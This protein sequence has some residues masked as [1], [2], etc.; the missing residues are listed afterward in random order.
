MTVG[1]SPKGI[2][3]NERDKDALNKQADRAEGI[4]DQTVDD[5]V[6]KQFRDAAKDYRDEAAGRKA[7]PS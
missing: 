6:K 5:E 7:R 2:R 1:A 4:A 3:M